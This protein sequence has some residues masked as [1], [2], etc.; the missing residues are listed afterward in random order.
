MART[1]TDTFWSR[2][3]AAARGQRR[4]VALAC[5]GL[6]LAALPALAQ[7]DP[8][9]GEAT[10]SAADGCARLVF[11][12]TEDVGTEVTTAGSIVVI[13]FERPV[14]VATEKLVDAVPDYVSMVRRDPDGTAIRL[15]L[16]RKVTLN[17]MTA[18]ER[19]FVDFMPDTWAGP[20]PSLPLDVVRE[21][22]ERARLAEKALRQQ[23]AEALAKKRPPIRVRALVQPTFVRFV[24]E[25]PD[26]V[27]ASS[28]L[29]DQKL[30]L[31]FTT[32]LNFDLADA[33]VAAPPNVASINQKVENDLTQ[34]EIALI[35]DVDV[36]SFREDKNYIID[37]A[38][39][40][41]DKP[42]AQSQL[43]P[44]GLR[45]PPELQMPA[46]AAPATDTK[47]PRASETAPARTEPGGPAAKPE[48]RS[49][50]TQPKIE[51]ASER[52]TTPPKMEA[53]TEI[54][55]EIK[56][57]IKAEPSAKPQAAM[58]AKQPSAAEAA[59]APAA[60]PAPA[61]SVA[62]K[63][64]GK[65]LPKEGPTA[66]TASVVA[67][68]A[69]EPS[70]MPASQPA[71]ADVAKK[72]AEMPGQD[73]AAPAK[74]EAV[75]D[76][77]G[78]RISF[79]FAKATPAASFRRGDTVW[80]VFDS[81]Q[82][83]DVEP[84]RTKGGAIVGE[85][86]RMPT[87]KGQAIRIRVNRPQMHTLSSDEFAAGSR[88]TLTFADKM[89]APALPL[90]V[91]RNITDPAH[92][93][94][95]VPFAG[96]GELHRITDP[97]AGDTLLVVTGLVPVRGLIKRQ[98][99]VDFTLLDTAHGV[100]VRPNSDSV[101]VEV[102]PDKVIV[103]KPGGLTI[104][105]VDASAER[106]PTAVRPVFDI[107][108]WHKNQAGQFIERR[109]A[110]IATAG[111]ADPENRAPARLALARFYMARGLYAEAAGEA[112][113]MLA[114]P[115]PKMEESV[116]LMVHAVASILIGQPARALKDL[117][118]PVVGNNYDS[119]L[120][121]GLAYARQHKWADARE[122][123][124]NV[125]FA[126]ASLPVELQRLVTMDAMRSCLEVRD[127][128][129]AA[130][131][132]SELE[133]VGVP[134]EMRPM[135]SVLYGR[136]A[137]ALGQEKDALDDYRFAI[138]SPDRE[139][140]AEATLHQVA[141]LQKRNEID[142]PEVLK[143]LE[144]LA[145]TW[146]GDSTEVRTLVMLAK[147]Y[148]D[149]ARYSDSLAAARMATRL[150]P[151]SEASRQA[152][153]AAQALFSDFF[154][155]AKGDEMPPIDALGLFYE[156]R[157]LTPIG[158]RG[159]E[160][161]RRLADRLVAVDLLDQ[162]AE[163]LQYQVD[164]RLE[165]AA[166]AQVAAKLAMVYLTNRKPEK[167]I[168]ALNSTRIADLNGELRAQRLLLEARA[169][170]DIGRHDLALD[171]ISNIGGRE[172][173][174][175]RSDINWAAR[176]WREASEQIELYYGDRYKDFKPLNPVE[177]ADIIRAVVGYALAEDAIG[178]ARFREKY[179]PLMSGEP[180]KIAFDTASK[181]TAAN[182]AEFTE[183]AKMAASVDTLDGFLREM[184]N[185]FPDATAWTP[186]SEKDR[187][188]TGSLPKIESVKR[189][190]AN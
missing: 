56:A 59:K 145:I 69:A 25:M 124:K 129:G 84:I 179:A 41:P 58:E 21:L 33:K 161:I 82:P 7:S 142:V 83:I 38:F 35:G 107:D 86:S 180:D 47:Q 117:A 65:A 70:A 104:S 163:L 160:M 3:R 23:R 162:A 97:E 8:V 121:R 168:M 85:V 152:Q 16:A 136:L 132:R 176:R 139:A 30:T 26:G 5:I 94:I 9:K 101:G 4:G 52:P 89:L 72:P 165:G 149:N 63:P 103:G 171:I 98:D 112:A 29:N 184:K 81:K 126:I 170:S 113:Y 134:D 91:L 87:D 151:N 167:A 181:P 71:A 40:Q 99:F 46:I 186:P 79:T 105:S 123:L 31:F 13:R 172:S 174:R 143:Q 12:F 190:S 111:A 110:L 154:L 116:F 76:S 37:V 138:D 178:L 36:H 137:E 108:E 159:D 175:L 92:A 24:F 60:A 55:T 166:R 119:Q 15:S 27:G 67:K 20:P 146:R 45:T 6:L 183:I 141:L 10:F 189:V 53:K 88:W 118:S 18:G 128:A 150:E 28:V 2:V 51:M 75:R 173:I 78:L 34:V 144:T 14:D 177:K 140:A 32:L 185:R 22:A 155:T 188:T 66:K 153:D 50:A 61:V 182:S 48:T 131:R 74:L 77:E 106:A 44:A 80:L 54:E 187:A 114:D 120:W 109:D 122:K 43:S 93:N 158:R 100:V 11:K 133:V 125:E 1:A 130:K 19:V 39:Q 157:E 57:D 96:G 156:F 68:N 95:A 62:E 115:T 64:A 164:K 90:M 102:A 135:A 49:E 147:I 17:T 169:Q 42:K 148:S 73:N 127:F